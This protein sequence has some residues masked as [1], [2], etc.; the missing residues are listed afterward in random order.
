MRGESGLLI[1]SLYEEVQFIFKQ[2]NSPEK[3]QMVA[4]LCIRLLGSCT[5]TLQYFMQD[6]AMRKHKL[7]EIKLSQ[8]QLRIV[9][10]KYKAEKKKPKPYQ[11]FKTSLDCYMKGRPERDSAG[12][13]M[14]LK[15]TEFRQLRNRITHATT[16][17][18]AA[19]SKDEL[20]LFVDAL[21]WFLN[22]TGAML[23]IE[24]ADLAEFN[25]GVQAELQEMMELPD[26]EEG[27]QERLKRFE[28]VKTR[29]LADLQAH[30]F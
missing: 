18:H 11:L 20:L 29:L 4:R 22:F 6:A 2:L 8:A 14:F 7:G 17:G 26:T 5:E 21:S 15:Y 30:K 25:E 24:S 28:P 23:K 10:R 1:M 27:R 13:E 9:S 16:F 3:T 12:M 19:L